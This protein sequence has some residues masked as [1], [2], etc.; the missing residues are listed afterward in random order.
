[1][2][3]LRAFFD[4]HLRL[5]KNVTLNTLRTWIDRIVRNSSQYPVV[6]MTNGEELGGGWQSISA[7]EIFPFHTFDILFPLNT[8][9]PKI[10]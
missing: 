6:K 2:L 8:R 7:D 10:I 1:M 4:S 9:L 3:Y 5:T